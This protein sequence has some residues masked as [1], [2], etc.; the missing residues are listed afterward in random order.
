M[1]TRYF[2]TATIGVIF[3]YVASCKKGNLRPVESSDSTDTVLLLK[4][5]KNGETTTIF[6]YDEH[7]KL[8]EESTTRTGSTYKHKRLYKYENDKI[9][10]I[11]S[12]DSS[13]VSGEETPRDSFQLSY[14][15]LGRL[16]SLKDYT[17]D[18]DGH[19]VGYEYLG[20]TVR[21][22]YAFENGPLGG[23]LDTWGTID[24][25]YDE[26]GNLLEQNGSWSSDGTTKVVYKGN[27]LAK[28]VYRKTNNTMY[29]TGFKAFN[30]PAEGLSIPT[31]L[32]LNNTLGYES[33]IDSGTGNME[34][35]DKEVFEYDYNSKGLPKERR[36]V[37]ERNGEVTRDTLIFKYS[38]LDE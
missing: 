11:K 30:S 1:K 16:S 31:V 5:I 2:I 9:I 6:K 27:D 7:G 14:D 21:L 8:I 17:D 37:Y 4:G 15:S 29:P 19:S 24:F 32:P 38:G 10:Q 13:I 18:Y 26:A 33:S 25:V 23:P 22:H 20:D 36:S 28:N 34:V 35:F 3:L 12:L